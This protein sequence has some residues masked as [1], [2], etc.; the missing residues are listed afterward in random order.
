MDPGA[1]EGTLGQT[2]CREIEEGQK[3]G[4]GKRKEK[5]KLRSIKNLKIVILK[6]VKS[7]FSLVIKAVDLASLLGTVALL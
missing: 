1:L 7:N 2:R 5:V 3:E 4:Q 6:F